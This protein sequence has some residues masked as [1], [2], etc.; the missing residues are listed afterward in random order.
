MA[1]LRTAR[2]SCVNSNTL[3]AIIPDPAQNTVV[4]R[5]EPAIEA[6]DG[7]RAAVSAGT[8]A[9][10]DGALDPSGRRFYRAMNEVIVSSHR[11]VR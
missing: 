4:D 2:N 7:S 10:I 11:I 1:L 9:F 6:A 5:D 3:L 8:E